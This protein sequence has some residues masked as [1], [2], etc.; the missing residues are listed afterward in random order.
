M[1]NKYI[2][3]KIVAVDKK[4]R[5]D[6]IKHEFPFMVRLDLNQIDFIEYE[7]GSNETKTVEFTCGAFVVHKNWLLTAAHCVYYKHENQ[8]NKQLFTEIYAS[9]NAHSQED[10]TRY[11]I[12]EEDIH[13]HFLYSFIANNKMI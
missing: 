11:L 8:N 3:T 5:S 9:F 10:G 1:R 6:A 12:P 13:P 4:A 2:D 7:D